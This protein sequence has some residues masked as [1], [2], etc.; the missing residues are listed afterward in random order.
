MVGVIICQTHFNGREKSHVVP[1][2]VFLPRSFAIG[3]LE[4]LKINYLLCSSFSVKAED[5]IVGT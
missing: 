5:Y 1:G 3:S 2:Y 4:F